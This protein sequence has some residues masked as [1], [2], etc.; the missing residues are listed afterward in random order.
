MDSSQLAQADVNSAH[1]EAQMHA[2]A[3]DVGDWLGADTSLPAQGQVT[4]L[5]PCSDKCSYAVPVMMA[6]M[7]PLLHKS[8]MAVPLLIST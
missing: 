7:N 4:S 8:I 1:A 3:G 5:H 2:H 6:P